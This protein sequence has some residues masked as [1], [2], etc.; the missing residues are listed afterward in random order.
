M[1]DRFRRRQLGENA[2]SDCGGE[3]CGDP[4]GYY[5]RRMHALLR[6]TFHQLQPELSQFNSVPRQFRMLRNDTQHVASIAR[7]V[8][9]RGAR[10]TATGSPHDPSMLES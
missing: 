4:A 1:R 7:E 9:A 5:P 10:I 6:K 8:E 3:R 2:I